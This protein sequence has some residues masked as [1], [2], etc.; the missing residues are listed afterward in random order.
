MTLIGVKLLCHNDM[1]LFFV[2]LS[3][4]VFE[5]CLIVELQTNWLV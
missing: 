4:R 5:L 1:H 2:R 3:R